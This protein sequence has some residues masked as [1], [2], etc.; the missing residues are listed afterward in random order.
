MAASIDL[1]LLYQ[2]FT[3]RQRGELAFETVVPS[4]H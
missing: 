1:V 2:F 3:R 4:S